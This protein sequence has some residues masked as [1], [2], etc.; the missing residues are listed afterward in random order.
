M[1]THQERFDSY[2]K[3]LIDFTDNIKNA[4]EV[5]NYLNEF[6]WGFIHP[7]LQNMYI[8]YF[9]K[10]KSKP[11]TTKQDVFKIFAKYFFDLKNTATFIDGIF[12]KRRCLLPFCHLIDQ[13]VFMC[14]QRDYAGAINALIPV[15]DG[16]IRYYLVHVKQAEAKNTFRMQE[17][18]KAFPLMKEDNLE[19]HREFYKNEWHKVFGARTPLTEEQAAELLQ[20]DA[21]SVDLWFSILLGYFENNLYLDTRKGAIKDELN[22]HSIFHG[23]TDK[24]YYNLE[25]Y[26]KIFNCVLFLS[27]AFCLSERGA[28]VLSNLTDDEILY[29]WSAFEKIRAVSAITTPIKKSVY[30][31]YAGFDANSFTEDFFPD[32]L[33]SH[34]LKMPALSLAH[35][36]HSIDKILKKSLDHAKQAAK[37]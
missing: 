26:L 13:S 14:L 21:Q 19:L 33:G 25:N 31:T 2:K 16:S 4:I 30:E 20:Y 22:R 28:S 10:L 15:I 5:N 27:Y 34:F 6:S 1:N 3:N 7:Y 17:L 35:R 23:F 29:K 24:I 18:L 37:R 36:L 12:K 11:S 9:R 8:D 32:E